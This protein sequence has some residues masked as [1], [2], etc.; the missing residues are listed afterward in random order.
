MDN[1]KEQT[2]TSG[3]KDP[4]CRPSEAGGRTGPYS[5][6][7]RPVPST[8]GRC[9]PLRPEA[10]RGLPAQVQTLRDDKPLVRLSA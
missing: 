9:G 10:E 8:L 7:R 1:H 5:S 4:E 3:Q 6:T 2:P